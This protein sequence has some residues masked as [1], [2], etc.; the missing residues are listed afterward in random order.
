MFKEVARCNEYRLTVNFDANAYVLQMSNF[1][2]MHGEMPEYTL[3]SRLDKWWAVAI[4]KYPAI[5]KPIIAAL[6]IFTGPWIEQIF[7]I[8]NH[9]VTKKKIVNS[10]ESAIQVYCTTERTN[11]K[12][13]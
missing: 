2:W 6:S 11:L 4:T 3:G 13:W 10:G 1:S 5:W 7:S 8:M 12:V 9:V